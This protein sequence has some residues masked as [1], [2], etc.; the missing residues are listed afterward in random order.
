MG[1]SNIL[2]ACMHTHLSA[3][4]IIHDFFRGKIAT[5]GIVLLQRFTCDKASLAPV[6]PKIG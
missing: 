5:P 6:P 2:S 3:S 1:T 4:K